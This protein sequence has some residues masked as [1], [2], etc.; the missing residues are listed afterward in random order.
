MFSHFSTCTDDDVRKIVLDSPSKFCSLDHVPTHIFK[1]FLELFLPFLTSVVNLCL[2]SGSFPAVFK[3]AII[4]PVLKKSTLDR[5]DISNYRPVSNLSFISKIIERVVAKQ[6]LHYIALNSL[7][8]IFQSGYRH[9]HSTETA[10]LNVV[11]ELFAAAD[12]QNVSLLALLDMSAAFD[13]VDYTLLLEKLSKSFGIM[14]TA[15]LWFKSYLTGRTQQVF[16]DNSLS[17]IET[18][19]FGVPQGSVLGPIL[20]L[21]Y[22]ADVFD[23]IEKF[24][25]NGY[26]FADDI[27][28]IACSNASSFQGIVDRLVL[29][30]SEIDLWMAKNRL[31]LNQCKTQFLPIG[32]WQQTSKIDF[33]SVNFNGLD[34]DFCSSATN[35]GFIF[36]TGLTMNAH[37]KSLTSKCSTQLRRLRMVKKSLNESTMQTLVHAFIHSRLDYCNSLFYGIS[38]KSMSKLQS[39]QNQ[40]AKIIVGGLK[41]D[42]ISPIL[43]D[44]HW[45]SVE[46]RI[47]FKIAILMYKCVN[48]LAPIYLMKKCVPKIV[49]SSHYQLRSNELNF[50][51]VPTT[52]LVVGSRS[53]SVFG[54]AVWNSLPYDLRQPGLS[55]TRFRKD[56][57]TY[58]FDR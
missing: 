40:A 32:T 51:L 44:L 41:F 29:C 28:I 31:K 33:D 18:L 27:Q 1:K 22:T 55:Y 25:L 45:L 6:L 11:S 35:L 23:I 53:F 15:A 49:S 13:C 46:K 8:P 47:L 38:N 26:A 39:I 50:L 21:L 30:L 5:G 2:I 24:G 10:L 4:T 43:R 56:L 34:V 19:S 20:F 57:K 36:D 9:F 3:H 12:A 58:L 54:P 16:F 7:M 52:R 37:I 48:G 14:G 42:H 17:E